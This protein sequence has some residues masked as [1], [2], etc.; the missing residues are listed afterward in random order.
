MFQI[1]VQVEYR[2]FQN[3][4]LYPYIKKYINHG[5]LTNTYLALENIGYV[6]IWAIIMFYLVASIEHVDYFVFRADIYIP[7]Y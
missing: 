4:L 6:E 1:L 3:S 5:L 2:H 7:V